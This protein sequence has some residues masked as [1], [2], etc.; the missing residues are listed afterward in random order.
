MSFSARPGAPCAVMPSLPSS[1]TCAKS[2]TSQ[3]CVWCLGYGV[4]YHVFTIARIWRSRRRRPR[5][6]RRRRGGGGPS[7]GGNGSRG[8]AGGAGGT[9]VGDGASSNV[10]GGSGASCAG[11][12][13]GGPGGGGCNSNGTG[14]GGGRCGSGIPSEM[15]WSCISAS[16]AALT[17]PLSLASKVCCVCLLTP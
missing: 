6:L 7:V 1:S 5:R 3:V 14:C 9:S 15:S 4:C 8:G 16:T 11:G 17:A 2:S 13:C 12:G 10:G